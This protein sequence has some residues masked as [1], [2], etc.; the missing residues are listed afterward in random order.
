MLWSKQ[1]VGRFNS[2]VQTSVGWTWA[3]RCCPAGTTW[4][5]LRSSWNSW[6]DFSSGSDSC[7]KH[8]VCWKFYFLIFH[9]TFEL[10]FSSSNRL[11]LPSDPSARCQAFCSLR[12][13]AL[14]GCQ[15][16]WSQ[17][18]III[19]LCWIYFCSVLEY[20]FIHSKCNIIFIYKNIN[21]IIE[22]N[23]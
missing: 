18:Q 21:Y 12:V 4:R 2:S 3:G 8:H 20:L 16:T 7:R 9:L 22:I 17:V 1:S 10:L 23:T 14:N 15:L 11:R 13:L 5:P 19:R 6:R